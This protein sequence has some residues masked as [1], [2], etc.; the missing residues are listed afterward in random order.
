MSL[1]NIFT[2]I[3]V[4]V[5]LF[6]LIYNKTLRE[7][8]NEKNTIDDIEINVSLKNNILWTTNNLENITSINKGT[9]FIKS[10]DLILSN[11]NITRNFKYN[12]LIFKPNKNLENIKVGLFNNNM[13]HYYDITQNNT[14]SIK[15]L[16]EEEIQN[17]DFCSSSILKKCMN[18]NNLYN[19]NQNDYLGIMIHN[20]IVHYLTITKNLNNNETNYSGNVIHKSIHKPT[21]PLKICIINEKND[22]MIDE[23]Y[24]LTNKFIGKP[25]K[26]SVNIIDMNQYDN[27]PLPPKESLTEIIENKKNNVK[28]EEYSLD[29]LAPW[30][31]KIFI[32][33]SKF[34]INTYD[35][36]FK[37]I[38]NMT[39]NNI[40]YLKEILINIVFNKEKILSIPYKTDN[41]LNEIKMNLTKYQKYLQNIKDFDIYIE[42]VRSKNNVDKNIISNIKKIILK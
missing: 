4:I 10:K 35:L 29:G 32:I 11:E 6:L 40:K 19:Y 24:W 3:I 27:E 38:T 14:F 22:N 36:E 15:E 42:L 31:K 20:N 18:K 21:Y 1:E 37:T 26:W 7:F 23:S 13:T 25:N 16:K 28:E 2:F 8:F 9:F 33:D 12:G 5:V 34:D 39:E 41:N 17:I 30:D